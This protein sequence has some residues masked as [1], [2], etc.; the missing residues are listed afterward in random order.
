MAFPT[1]TFT[2]ADLADLI[3]E[4]WGDKINDF[5]KSKLVAGNFFTDRSSEMSGGA[6][7]LYTPNITEMTAYAKSNA[8]AVNNMAAL[9][10]ARV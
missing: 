4:V 1:D 2:A 10:Y 9:L 3:P 6:D 8:T 7:A 5:Y